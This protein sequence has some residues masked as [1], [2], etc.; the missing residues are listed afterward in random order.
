M[1]VVCHG[2]ADAAQHKRTEMKEM[3]SG[4]R[5]LPI[6]IFGC[7]GVTSGKDIGF[8]VCAQAVPCGLWD[9]DSCQSCDHI[10]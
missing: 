7:W 3:K 5:N 9:T 8:F 6:W 2:D 4:H 1:P 10:S